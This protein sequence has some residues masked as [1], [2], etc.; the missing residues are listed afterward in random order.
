MALPLS[1]TF[2]YVLKVPKEKG[3]DS[4]PWQLELGEE[5]EP[6]G[7]D[8]GVTADPFG[9]RDEVRVSRFTLK[10][11]EPEECFFP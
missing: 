10:G 11:H 4:F 6:S 7:G 3:P 1:E 8:G 2:D 5:I 9:L